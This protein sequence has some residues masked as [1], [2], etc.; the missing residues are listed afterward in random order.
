MMPIKEMQQALS[1]HQE[2]LLKMGKRILINIY[3][4]DPDEIR[5]SVKYSG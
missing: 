2:L 5:V 1:S 3:Y 4:P